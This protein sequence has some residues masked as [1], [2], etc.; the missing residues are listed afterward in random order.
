MTVLI[1]EPGQETQVFID[2]G[3]WQLPDWSAG[4]KVFIYN[5]ECHRGMWSG[6]YARWLQGDPR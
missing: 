1:Q 6:G 4:A 3:S 5:S 2:V